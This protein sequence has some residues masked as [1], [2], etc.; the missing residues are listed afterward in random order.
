MEVEERK[1]MKEGL[2][3]VTRSALVPLVGSD[4]VERGKT[5]DEE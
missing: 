2:G 5:I 3:H 4:A 1:L